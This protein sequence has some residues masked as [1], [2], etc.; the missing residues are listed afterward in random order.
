MG[1]GIQIKGILRDR[2][3]TIKQL[4]EKTGISLNTLY[5]ITKRDSV[6][7]D[8]VILQ[9]MA[10]TL[11]VHILDLIGVSKQF[12]S[13]DFKISE[14]SGDPALTDI[15]RGYD[16]LGDDLK[17]EFLARIGVLPSSKAPNHDELPQTN[18]RAKAKKAPLYSSEAEE[19]LIALHRT[20][21]PEGQEKLLDYA[22]DLVASGKY[23]KSD[24]D[25]LGKAR[26][27]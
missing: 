17:T 13:Y 5:S 4:S 27:A 15:K 26:N 2:N 3:M 9:R 6:R 8:R 12:D 10:D 7:V 22:D 20:L 18:S 1:V 16:S 25:K 23:I 11:D 14:S 24:P 19:Q 21:N